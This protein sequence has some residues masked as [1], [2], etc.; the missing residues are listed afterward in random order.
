MDVLT[1]N[2]QPFIAKRRGRNA[3]TV[4]PLRWRNVLDLHLAGHKANEIALLTGFSLN[5][6]Y[7]ILNHKDTQ[8]IRQQLLKSTWDEAEALV[9]KVIDSVRDDLNS[10]DPDRVS[11]ARKDWIKLYGKPQEEKVNQ[12]S[13]EQMV[14]QILNGDVNN[15]DEGSRSD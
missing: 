12:F 3:Y 1:Q 6:I 11:D 8:I 14:F 5:S 13:A 9:T 10:D 4:I 2:N 7:R 15:G